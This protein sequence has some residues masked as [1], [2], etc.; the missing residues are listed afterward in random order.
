M[1]DAIVPARIPPNAPMVA[2]Y[3]DGEWPDYVQD[4]SMFPDAV[5]VDIATNVE[6]DAQVLDVESG[7]PSTVAN[8]Y[9]K[10]PIWCARQRARGQIPTVY[11]LWANYAAVAAV[12]KKAGQP[13]PEWWIANWDLT[14]DTAANEI[15]QYGFVAVQ[16]LNTPGYD[17]SV[18]ADHW[19]GVDPASPQPEEDDMLGYLVHDQNDKYWVVAADFSSRTEVDKG[20]W[21]AMEQTGKYLGQTGLTAFT[22]APDVTVR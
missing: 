4:K 2:G 16:Y 18:V 14:V 13:S 9:A 10:V 22:A 3:A 6:T 21:Y 19:P 1:Y 15:V 17:V 20:T 12:I 5:L 8:N 7:N 11:C